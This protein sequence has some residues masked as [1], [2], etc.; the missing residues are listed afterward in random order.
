MERWLMLAR[1]WFVILFVTFALS[2]LV[3]GIVVP[4]LHLQGIRLHAWMMWA[5]FV[6][7]FVLVWSSTSHLFRPAHGPRT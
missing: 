2:G 5:I 4:A 6:V 3:S 7:S 1:R